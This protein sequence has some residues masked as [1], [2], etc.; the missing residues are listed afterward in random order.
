MSRLPVNLIEKDDR[1][2]V[3]TGLFEKQSQLSL[4]LSHPLAQTVRTLAHEE[5]HTLARLRAGVSQCA[6]SESLA[7]TGG[8]IEQHTYRKVT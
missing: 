2:L 1:G 4:C 6:C 8:A 5:C 7:A 3:G